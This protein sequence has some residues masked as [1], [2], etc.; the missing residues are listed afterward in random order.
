M[1][2]H[3]IAGLGATTGDQVGGA[4]IHHRRAIPQR[5]GRGLRPGDPMRLSS[6]SSAS[7]SDTIACELVFP[8][9]DPETLG[10]FASLSARRG[11]AD[12][13]YCYRILTLRD[14]STK[15]EASRS[16]YPCVSHANRRGVVAASGNYPCFWMLW[17][18]C[19]HAALFKV[20]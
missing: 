13:R 11:I 2:V 8:L 20:G 5:V 17:S 14:K 10:I 7:L 1:P 18:P 15:S 6:W 12:S 19:F 3:E 4:P 9:N 16:A